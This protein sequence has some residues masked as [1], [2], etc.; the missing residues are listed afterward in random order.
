MK[1]VLLFL[2]SFTLHFAIGQF[3]YTSFEEPINVGG[4]YTDTGDAAVDHALVNNSEEPD[5]NFTSTGGELG[6]TS[7][8]FNTRDDV[9]LTDGDY[10]GVTNYTGTVTAY[11]DGSNGFELSDTDGKMTVTFDAVSLVGQTNPNVSLQYFVQSTGYESDDLIRIWLTVDGGTEIDLLNTTGSDINDLGIEGSWLTLSSSLSGYTT[12]TLK[13]EMDCNSGTEALYIDDIQFVAGAFDTEVKFAS[14][15]ASVNEGDGTY[16]LLVSIVN[17]DADNATSADVVL[18]SGDAVD[19]NNYTTQTVTFPANSS[20]DQTVVITIT[21]DSDIEGTE[22]LTFELQNITGG[23]NASSGNPSQ[24]ELTIQ[25]NDFAET[26]DI[27][28]NEIMQN[29]SA[30][31]DSNGEWFELYNPG[32]ADVDIDGWTIKDDGSDSHLIDNGGPL[33]IAADGYLVLGINDGATNSNGGVTV[34]YVYSGFTLANGDDEVVLVYSDGITEVDRVN[35]DGGTN[36][37]DPT[38][39]SM[40]L[41]NPGYDNNVGSNWG[42]ATAPYG[43]GDLGTPGSENSI[44]SSLEPIGTQHVTAFKLYANYPN[45]FNPS[46]TLRFDVPQ[47]VEN[48]EL[49]VYDILGKKVNTLHNGSVVAGQFS[50][51]W[52]G[53]NQNNLAV[54]SGVYFAVLKTRNFSQSIKM[55]LLK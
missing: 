45:P 7:Y 24:F 4:S 35:Y 20:D 38:G 13:V 29:P 19:I 26:P 46:T 53:V 33:T 14:S 23:N 28:I 32:L 42:V 31:D 3:A 21:D 12:A 1:K 39:A 51:Q 40:E 52:N 10:V 8:Y 18:I 22:M 44:L 37:P 30:V 54:P 50:A 36:Y 55:M 9:G 6:F 15:D 41:R 48:L 11:P 49:T 16:N 25:D 5:V 2:L 27:V 34:D 17:P 43:D 47:A